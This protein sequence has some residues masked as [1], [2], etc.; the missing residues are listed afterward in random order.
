MK[1]SNRISSSK[2]PFLAGFVEIE[3]HKSFAYPPLDWRFCT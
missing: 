2:P 3:D 1:L